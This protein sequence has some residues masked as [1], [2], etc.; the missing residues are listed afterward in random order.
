M[1]LEQAYKYATKRAHFKARQLLGM[2]GFTESDFED[3][4]QELLMHVLKQMPNFDSDKADIRVFITTVIDKRIVNMIEEQE[5]ECRDYRRNERSLDEPM[6]DN[7][8]DGEDGGM[9]TF[10][11]TITE[12]QADARLGRVRRSPLEQADLAADMAK[13]LSRL[14]SRDR[15]ICALMTTHNIREICRRLK[16][17]HFCVYQRIKTIRRVFTEASMHEY[18]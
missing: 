2:H 4:Q 9:T 18:L 15:R 5:A 10:G 14:S 17:S 16:L 7:G 8:D 3:I 13:V 1:T 6:S 12:E 11:D